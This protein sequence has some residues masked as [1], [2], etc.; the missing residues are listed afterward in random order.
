V[1]PRIGAKKLVAIGG[2]LAVGITSA[3]LVTS[4]AAQASSSYGY[5]GYAH[6][7]Y[8]SMPIADSGPQV[9]SILSCTR[10][11]GLHAENNAASAKASGDTIAHSVRTSTDTHN[12]ARGD[13]TTSTGSADEVQLGA[14]LELKGVKTF[15]RAV[16]KNGVF[17]TTAGTTF[18]AVKI[19]GVP[20]PALQ[21][22]KANQKVDVPG[23]GY[24][25]FNRQVFT[26][27]G[28]SASSSASAVLIHA[29]Q[30]NPYFEKGST[31]A[32]LL[33]KAEVGGSTVA[34]LTGKT[35]LTQTRVGDMV[36]SGPTSFQVT[37]VGTD[38][39]VVEVDAAGVTLPKLGQIGAGKT[40]KSG[41]IGAAPSG[42]MKAEIANGNLGDGKVKFGNVLAKATA[43]KVGGKV[44]TSWVTEFSSMIVDGKVIPVPKGPNQ[45]YD[46]P[47]FGTITLNQVKQGKN[48]VSVTA[49]V[50]YVKALNTTMEIAHAE[51]GVGS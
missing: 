42:W 34:M 48:G 21:N 12:D 16:S 39:K 22:P 50:V 29:T 36:K 49:M 38:G 11:A 10:R 41:V 19:A 26:K 13:G 44:S 28:E 31:V 35:Y 3:V 2:V 47:G 24:V 17:E 43:S 8:V 25:V 18:S 51:A 9:T 32:V 7:T 15:S 6:G 5:S 23:L 33:T 14:L 1:R 37:C 40:S 4:G 30:L 45:K 27:T 46:V 20:V